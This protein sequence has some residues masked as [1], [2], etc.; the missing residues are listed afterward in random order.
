MEKKSNDYE[1]IS[2]VTLLDLFSANFSISISS[3]GHFLALPCASVSRLKLE[4]AKIGPDPPVILT[5]GTARE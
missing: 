3:P 1:T 4:D 2:R 5:G